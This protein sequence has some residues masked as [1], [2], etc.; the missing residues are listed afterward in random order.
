M[1]LSTIINGF[2]ELATT[3]RSKL[4][5]HIFFD[6]ASSMRE[7]FVYAWQQMRKWVYRCDLLGRRMSRIRTNDFAMPI[8]EAL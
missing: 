1:Q 4:R 6:A 2:C 5:L 8:L 3:R 7:N